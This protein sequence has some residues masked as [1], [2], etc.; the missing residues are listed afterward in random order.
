MDIDQGLR[1]SM[2]MKQVIIVA[3]L[4]FVW[5]HCIKFVF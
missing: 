3:G 2:G 1:V 5:A 4:R